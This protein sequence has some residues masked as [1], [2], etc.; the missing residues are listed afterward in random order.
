MCILRVVYTHSESTHVACSVVDVGPFLIS[1]FL[2]DIIKRESRQGG[3]R[4]SPDED[5]DDSVS[6]QEK[7]YLL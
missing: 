7:R 1:L 5:G 3:Q 6:E 2:Q 4:E